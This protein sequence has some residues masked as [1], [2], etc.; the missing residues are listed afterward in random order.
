MKIFKG[1]ISLHENNNKKD[2]TSTKLTV[3]GTSGPRILR[4]CSRLI[5]VVDM[6]ITQHSPSPKYGVISPTILIFQE[7]D[8]TNKKKKKRG[9]SWH[10][11]LDIYNEC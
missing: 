9:T 1:Q 6:Y 5:L 7:E 11:Y 8:T 3:D 10:F 2:H 4:I